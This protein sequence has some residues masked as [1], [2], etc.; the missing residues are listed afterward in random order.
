MTQSLQ[1][2]DTAPDEPFLTSYDMGHLVTYLRLL[3]ADEEGAGWPEV[4]RI[5][6]NLDVQKDPDRTKRIWQSHLTRARWMTTSGYRHAECLTL[7]SPAKAL[8]PSTRL[9]SLQPRDRH[10]PRC[11]AHVARSLSRFFGLNGCV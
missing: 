2:A 5:V 11:C 6:L 8:V 4:A 1:I 7:L 3:D 9:A 10:S